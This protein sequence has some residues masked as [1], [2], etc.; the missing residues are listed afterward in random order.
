[1]KMMIL[2]R[3]IVWSGT[4]E[5]WEDGKIKIISAVN[6]QHFCASFVD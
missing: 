1:M 4:E 3:E 5:L 2:A 6:F